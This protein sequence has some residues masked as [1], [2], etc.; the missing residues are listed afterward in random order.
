MTST[1]PELQRRLGLTHLILYGLGVTIGAGIYVLV[2]L[3]AE[4]AGFFAPISFLLAALVVAFTGFT[5]SE[6][7]A[8][9]PVSAGEAAYVKNA[10]NFRWLTLLVGCLVIAS[11]IVSSATVSLGASAYLRHFIPINPLILTFI[12]IFILGFIAVW[13][14]LES[15]TVAAILTVIEF[16]GLCILVLYAALRNPDILSGL[17]QLV[18]P[19]EMTAW[20]GIASGGLLA[21]FAFI[22]FE[23]LA[24]IA[25]EAKNPKKNMPKAIILTLIISTVI[26]LIVV[27]TVVLS[28]PMDELTSSA[29]PLAL[30]FADADDTLRGAFI[31]IAAVATLNGVLIQMIMASRVVYG[32]ASQGEFPKILSIIHPK[33]H[34]PVLA[35]IVVV[36]I[37]LA[38]AL[39][40]PIDK[41][42][43]MTSQIVLIAFALVNLA[44]IIL[45]ATRK[46]NNKEEFHVPMIIPVVGFI[47]CI[48]LLLSSLI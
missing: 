38:L 9:F 8:C 34:T 19:L 30:V 46:L 2:G 31:L 27:S 45:K 36:T 28:V 40:F 17:N 15:V 11:G 10:F 37:I 6:L 35:T 44:L 33:T 32:M 21:F 24:N 3:T 18:P 29:S 43:V 23:D 25:E 39:F 4:E 5:Y 14:I 7:T 16:L 20:K 1:T 26:Y 42:A 22:G 41:L 13:G 47:S 12:V 48:L